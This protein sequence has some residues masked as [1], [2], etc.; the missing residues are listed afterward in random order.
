MSTTNIQRMKF[1]QVDDAMVL[2]ERQQLAKQAQSLLGYKRLAMAITIPGTLLG[3]LRELG[4]EP[5][6]N[7]SVEAYK[8]RKA[9]PGMWSGTRNTWLRLAGATV[10]AFGITMILKLNP[11]P[12]PAAIAGVTMCVIGAIICLGC[13]LVLFDEQGTRTVRKW[14]QCNLSAY[15]GNVPEFVLAKAIAIKE[16]RPGVNFSVDQ[17]FEEREVIERDPDPFLIAQLGDEHYYID[18]WDEKEYEAQL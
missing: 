3:A 14:A 10:F 18:V 2:D 11:T 12:S 4:I 15:Q 8:A 1:K 5:L 16:T 13:T 17:L 7:S 6:V 9:R